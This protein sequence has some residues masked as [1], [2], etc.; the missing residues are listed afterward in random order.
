MRKKYPH[1]RYL[2]VLALRAGKIMMRDFG[3]AKFRLKS[4]GTPIT[5]ADNQINKMVVDSFAK[6]FPEVEV[7]GEEGSRYVSGADCRV[8]FDA[9]D[10]TWDFSSG[11][12][13]FS[14]CIAVVVD[15]CPIISLIYDPVCQRMWHAILGEGVFLNGRKTK[16]SNHRQIQESRLCIIWW[17]D[18]PYC[19]GAVCT[20]AIKAGAKWINP[21]SIAYFGGLVASGNIEATIFPGQFPWE[22]AA[23]QL[24]VKEAGG[25]FTD[26]HGERVSFN[27]RRSVVCGHIASN[28][29]MHEELVALVKSCQ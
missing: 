26:I 24:I 25:K 15:G 28:G 19:L 18:S 1:Y 20:K 14:F 10:A 7:I 12:P 16:V 5:G 13:L 4:D 17:K 23:M 22:A 9:I 27:S 2:Y 6:D 11:I 29:L 8:F 21:V 3:H